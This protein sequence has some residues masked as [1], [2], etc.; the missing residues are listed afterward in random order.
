[1]IHPNLT[2]RRRA[3]A[4]NHVHG[5]RTLTLPAS[6]EDAQLVHISLQ[7]QVLPLCRPS[8]WL[9]SQPN[10]V[11][12]NH[13]AI[14]MPTAHAPWISRSSV[15]LRLSSLSGK[16]GKSGCQTRLWPGHSGNQQAIGNSG[17]DSTPYQGRVVRFNK[18]RAPGLDNRHRDDA[19]LYRTRKIIRVQEM[20]RSLLRQAKEGRRWVSRERLRSFCGLCVSL[21]LPM[22]YAR[23]YS[24]SLYDDMSTRRVDTH[25][26]SRNGA[27]CRL[28]HSRSAT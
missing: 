6:A 18:S 13:E 1:M 23:F 5:P 25:V 26:S 21:S 2:G 3:R 28:S 11:Y 8:V 10:V 16:S 15:P 14:D 7:E 22:P 12:T 9:G 27:R 24:R 19:F 4:S 17:F 20:A